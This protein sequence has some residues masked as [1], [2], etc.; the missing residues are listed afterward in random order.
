MISCVPFPN[1]RS[2]V[3]GFAIAGNPENDGHPSPWQEAVGHEIIPD[4][5]T[6]GCANAQKPRKTAALRIL[7]SGAGDGIRTHDPN[8]GKVVLYP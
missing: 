2:G 5:H 6:N 3:I 8:L 4:M 1:C 7:D